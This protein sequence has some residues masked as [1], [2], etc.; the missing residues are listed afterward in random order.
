MHR[1]MSIYHESKLVMESARVNGEALRS[2][3]QG[4]LVTG[5]GIQAGEG[6]QDLG[7]GVGIGAERQKEAG[8]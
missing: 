1:F 2:V 5:N 3:I 6:Q 4:E 7:F 8:G